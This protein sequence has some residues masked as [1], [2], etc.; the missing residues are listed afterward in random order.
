MLSL[1]V[2]VLSGSST[3][4]D[5]GQSFRHEHSSTIF[6]RCWGVSLVDNSLVF[7]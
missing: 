4:Q 3:P 6:R 5:G 7:F 1:S 2:H